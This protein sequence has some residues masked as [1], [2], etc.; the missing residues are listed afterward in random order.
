MTKK[1]VALLLALLLMLCFVSCDNTEPASTPA[2]TQQETPNNAPLPTAT[3]DPS[4]PYKTMNVGSSKTLQGTCLIIN[5]FLSD[6]ESSF[7]EKEKNEYFDDLF[8]ALSYLSEEAEKYNQ[9]ISFIY[10]TGDTNLDHTVDYILPQ[11]SLDPMA[12]WDYT[13][14]IENLSTQYNIDSVIQKYNPDNV[15]F[16]VV[17]NKEGRAYAFPN[18]QKSTSHFEY[19][20]IYSYDGLSSTPGKGWVS[21]GNSTAISHEILHLFGAIDLYDLESEKLA[22]ATEFFPM[23]I[24]LIDSPMTHKLTISNLDAYLIGWEDELDEKYQIFLK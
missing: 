19:A 7:T 23:D 21:D 13:Q 9:T 6:E 4:A 16:M 11:D 15:F 1:A 20:T 3:P 8:T 12:E 10:N 18:I 17:I 24:M 22:L 2:P 5:V 14:L